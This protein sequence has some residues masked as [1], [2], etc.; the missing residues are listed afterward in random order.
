LLSCCLLPYLVSSV[1]S[2]TSSVLQTPAAPNWLWGDWLGTIVDVDGGLYMILAEG[3]ICCVGTIGLLIVILGLLL[4]I[5]GMGQQEEYEP[6]TG[7]EDQDQDSA[8]TEWPG[9]P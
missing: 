1:Y 4:A 3:P 7:M 2:V 5:S 6:Y 8:A 9:S